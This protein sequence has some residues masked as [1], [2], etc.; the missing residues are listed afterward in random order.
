[1]FERAS[2]LS[3]F[4]AFLID[5]VVFAALRFAFSFISKI[6]GLS[7]DLTAD[8]L[9]MIEDLSKSPNPE[10]LLSLT[11][12]LQMQTGV[13]Y[14]FMAFFVLFFFLMIY[15][16]TQKGGTPGKLAMG[17]EIQDVQT[18]QKLKWWQAGLR[19]FI[20][21]TILWPLTLLIGALACFFGANRRGIHDWIAGSAL[22]Q[23]KGA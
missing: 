7:R 17:L 8:E 16:I 19:E 12:D 18:Y 3:R 23:K 20:G 15:L 10:Q 22:R 13:H 6:V 14:E 4:F 2:N 5:F 1:M 21:K 11:L 9:K